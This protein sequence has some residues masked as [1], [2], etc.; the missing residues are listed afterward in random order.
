MNI[1]LSFGIFVLLQFINVALNTIKVI[2]TVKAS[3]LVSA[4]INAVTYAFYYGVLK[5]VVETDFQVVLIG[6]ILAN[7]LGVPLGTW[8]TEK[9]EKE[10]LWVIQ[11]NAK[12]VDE[13]V[14][15]SRQLFE[16]DIDYDFIGDTVI[17]AH[18]SNRVDSHN[19]R[20]ML[21]NYQAKYIV[22]VIEKG[23]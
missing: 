21:E 13:R 4:L 5:I 2:W 15:I 9:L 3:K 16:L 1:W 20:K 10:K 19:I 6:T 11:I 23:L 18:S 17:Q 8:V 22:N 14:K 12:N 7:L